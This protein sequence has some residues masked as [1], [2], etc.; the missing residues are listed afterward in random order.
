M[1]NI[2]CIIMIL[3]LIS[4]AS[5]KRTVYRTAGVTQITVETAL[6]SWDRYV[7]SGKATIEQERI[8]KAAYEKYQ[9]AALK[10]VDVSMK[11]SVDKDK[12]ALDEAI[13]LASGTLNELINLIRSYGV[14]I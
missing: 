14:K 9:T 13:A 4:C 6:K 7:E 10:V 8:V 11:Y 3:F 5:T 12:L 1:K 2:L